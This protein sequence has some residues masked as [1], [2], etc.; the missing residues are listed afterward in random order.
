MR[1]P[2]LRCKYVSSVGVEIECGIPDR[3][4]IRWVQAFEGSDSRFSY[5]SDGSVAVPNCY[6]SD[7]E[8]RYWA[9][10]EE[11]G[12][13]VTVLRWLWEEIGIR[14]NASCGNHIHVKL[15]Q[16]WMQVLIHPKF[17]RYFQRRYINFARK[18]N[19]PEK[20]IAR[21]IGSY[22]A[23]YRWRNYQDLE[24]QV[25]ESYQVSG[26]RYRSINYWSLGDSQRTLEFRIMPW[27]SC[28]MEHINMIVFVVRTVEQYCDAVRKGKIELECSETIIS[29]IIT[30]SLNTTILINYREVGPQVIEVSR[31]QL[32]EDEVIEVSTIL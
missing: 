22:S 7:A 25:R 2:R 30:S 32:L 16:D 29:P 6:D 31:P 20:Y 26:S 14:Q 19:N 4:G 27:A 21:T 5:G 28:F 24:R 11:W 3:D 15:Q 12:R 13:F 10:I 23:F 17:V 8:L 9:P 1:V 18:Q